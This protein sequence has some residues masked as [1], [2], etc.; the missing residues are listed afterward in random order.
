MTDGPVLVV[1]A[2]GMLGGQVATELPKRGKRVVP[3]RP[4]RCGH[5]P[6]RQ[7]FGEPPTAELPIRRFVTGLGQTVRTQARDKP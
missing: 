2:T 7:Y 5:H 4:V 6:Q 1:G 3:D